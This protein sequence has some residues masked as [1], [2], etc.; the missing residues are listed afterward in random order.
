MSSDYQST[1]QE[2]TEGTLKKII[3]NEDI[4]PVT[5]NNQKYYNFLLTAMYAHHQLYR[6]RCQHPRQHKRSMN[7]NYWYKFS[8]SSE[9]FIRRT[10]LLEASRNVK[11]KY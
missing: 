6:R 2:E 9:L 8:K 4:A 3:V 5:L 11:N 1:K 10:A 7:N